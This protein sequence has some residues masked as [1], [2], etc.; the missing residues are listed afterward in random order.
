MKLFNTKIEY[1][2]KALIYLS[3]FGVSKLITAN[4]IAQELS[5]PK[6]YTSKI[7]Q[8]FARSGF[9]TSKKGKGG[10]FILKKEPDELFMIDILTA[11][12][13]SEKTDKCLLG[14]ERQLRCDEC[15]IENHWTNFMKEF[16]SSL[17]G[18]NLQYLLSRH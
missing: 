8:E 14:F 16:I 17:K 10:G 9:V 7:L 5:I 3:K 13:I 11:L 1:G 6:E 15:F 12:G 18:Q 4:A 2:F